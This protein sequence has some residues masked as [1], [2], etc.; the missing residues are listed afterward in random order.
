M[1]VTRGISHLGL[2]VNDLAASV[3]AWPGV[4][5]GFM[6]EFLGTGPRKHMM[7]YQPGG[8]RLELLWPGL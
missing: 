5:I 1:S 4:E 8:I 7:F 3:K 6:P 2:S